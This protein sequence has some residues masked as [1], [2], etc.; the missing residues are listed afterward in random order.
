MGLLTGEEFRVDGKDKGAVPYG[1]LQHSQSSEFRKSGWRS[2]HDGWSWRNLHAEPELRKK[3]FYDCYAVG[4]RR[5]QRHRTSGAILA[6]ADLLT[7][8][9]AAVILP[10]V[11]AATSAIESDRIAPVQPTFVIYLRGTLGIFDREW[12]ETIQRPL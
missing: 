10:R 9:Y 3:H 8:E 5:R 11:I 1:P 12:P 7:P 2:L 6:E 4:R